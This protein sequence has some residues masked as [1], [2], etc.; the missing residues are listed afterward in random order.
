LI[1]HNSSHDFKVNLTYFS[2]RINDKKAVSCCYPLVTVTAF[3]TA[4]V[5]S[6]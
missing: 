6:T 2:T 1:L 3:R 5:V 4:K